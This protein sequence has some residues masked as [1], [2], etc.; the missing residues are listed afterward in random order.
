MTE[1]ELHDLEAILCDYDSAMSARDRSRVA[2]LVA[3][4]RKLRRE[5]QELI[6]R[7]A[8]LDDLH[9]AAVLRAE[10]AEVELEGRQ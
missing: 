8:T 5:N 9:D 1:Q 3:T 6:S 4:V 2:L 7:M 10:R